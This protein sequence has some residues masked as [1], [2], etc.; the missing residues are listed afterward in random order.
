[1]REWI[2]KALT[3]STAVR[4]SRGGTVYR[5]VPPEPKLV[6]GVYFVIAGLIG[7]ISLEIVH[8]I[9]LR[10]WNSEIFAAITGLIGTILGV[11]F[12]SKS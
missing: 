2:R 1:M 9:V 3:R 6:Y 10:A 7:L 12:G 5:V 11:F 8:L 4:G